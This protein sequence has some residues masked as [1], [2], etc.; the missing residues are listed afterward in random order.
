MT[1]EIFRCHIRINKYMYLGGARV[2]VIDQTQGYPF[3]Q[4]F[5]DLN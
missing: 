3:T 5:I 1:L 2:L 4:L